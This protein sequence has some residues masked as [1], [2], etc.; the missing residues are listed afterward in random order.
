MDTACVKGL[1]TLRADTVWISLLNL[2]AGEW[3]G[4]GS[5]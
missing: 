1:L 3:A 5:D 2:W 4:D